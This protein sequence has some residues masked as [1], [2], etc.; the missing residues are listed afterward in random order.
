MKAILLVPGALLPE[1]VAAG[2]QAELAE[3]GAVLRS[4][5]RG[6]RRGGCWH[7]P[8][9]AAGTADRQWL[10]RLFGGDAAPLPAGPYAW[11]ALAGADDGVGVDDDA[12]IAH[13]D[14]VHFAL[15]QDHIRMLALDAAPLRDDEAA[16][17]LALANEAAAPEG[18]RFAIRDG[19]WFLRSPEV[20]QIDTVAPDTVFGQPVERRMPT[21]PDARR[22][23]IVANEIQMR[24]HASPVNDAREERGAPAVNALWLHG[25]GRWTPLAESSIGAIRGGDAAVRGWAQ[26]STQPS[27]GMPG[28]GADAG[29]TVSIHSELQPAFRRQDWA[30]WLDRLPALGS[31][32]DREIAEARSRGVR[33]VELVLAG[34]TQVQPYAIAGRLGWWTRW[35]GRTPQMAELFREPAG[36]RR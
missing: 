4:A 9:E 31:W 33:E 28:P 10:M 26:A 32:L 19:A 21:G 3:R 24:W 15:A 13:C 29:D 18:W 22:W 2:L 1:A 23:R 17:L 34:A 35:T 7:A 27:K 16:A 36:A 14:P 25:G 5:L 20:L 6:A 8:D 12:W 11:R 30:A